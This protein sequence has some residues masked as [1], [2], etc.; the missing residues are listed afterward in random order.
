MNSPVNIKQTREQLL[1]RLSTRRPLYEAIR[2]NLPKGKALHAE[3]LEPRVLLS[4][5]LM[6]AAAAVDEGLEQVGDL[7][8]QFFDD[9]LLNADVPLLV[10]PSD[11]GKV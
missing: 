5:D 1:Q 6:A 8:D 4:A 7:L 2:E 3:M 10:L 11:S 9:D